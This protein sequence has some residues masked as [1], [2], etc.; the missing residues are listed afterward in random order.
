MPIVSVCMPV[1]NA[2]KYLA[3]AIDSILSQTYTDFDFHIIDDGSSDGSLQILKQ[4]AR[5]DNR[6]RIISRENRG[7]GY[8]RNEL[9]R[10]AQ[11]EYL[12]IMDADD[13]ALPERLAVQVEFL[14]AHKEVVCVGGGI[15]LIDHKGRRIAPFIRP[16]DDE[17]I[18]QKALEGQLLLPQP[19]AMMRKTAVEQVGE[20]DSHFDGA[21]DMDLM[22]RLGEIGKLANI[23]KILLMYRVHEKSISQRKCEE[24]AMLAWEACERAWKRRGIEGKITHRNLPR[25]VHGLK[26]QY[27]F[28]MKYGWWAFNAGERRTAFVYSLSSVQLMPWRS[29]AWRLLACTLIKPT[30]P[31]NDVFKYSKLEPI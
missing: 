29:D 22:L 2:E 23:P 20:Y 6:I 25:P 3:S 16:P 11:G 10:Q 26:H 13:I 1:Y 28:T 5:Q 4:Y 9:F 19:C 18:Q 27:D 7:V 30:P 14:D 21:E 15:Y 24:Q 31:K 12:A 8:T 17:T